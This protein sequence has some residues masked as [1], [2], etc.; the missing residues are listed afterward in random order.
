[1]VARAF[2]NGDR[3]RVADGEALAGDAAEVAF[4]RDRAIE[5]RVADDDRLFRN[6]LRGRRRID[7]KTAARQSLA[8]IVV[9]LAFK[10]ERDAMSDPRAEAL[11]GRALELHMDRVVRKTAMAMGLGDGA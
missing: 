11:A 2:D 3:A 4:A 1:M 8:D 7:D 5:D 9:R 10:L 6:D